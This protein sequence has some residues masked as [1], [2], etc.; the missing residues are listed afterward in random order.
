MLLSHF[1]LLSWVSC[2]ISCSEGSTRCSTYSNDHHT[3]EIGHNLQSLF[4]GITGADA[5][6]T[7]LSQQYQHFD[8]LES[9]HSSTTTA[10]NILSVL[11]VQ[12]LFGRQRRSLNPYRHSDND[13][14]LTNT[15]PTSQKNER[16]TKQATT[17]PQHKR[18]KNKHF[19]FWDRMVKILVLNE[20]KH[21][22]FPV[23]EPNLSLI[24]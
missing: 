1:S 8:F 7:I 17:Q 23:L 9:S 13:S 14:W 3:Q 12:R 4:T 24:V 5:M 21:W 19:L 20:T 16:Q 18:M 2:V 10:S 15:H 22:C 11:L 6:T